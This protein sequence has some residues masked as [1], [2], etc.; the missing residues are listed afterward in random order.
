MEVSLDAPMVDDQVCY[1]Q[2]GG[3]VVLNNGPRNVRMARKDERLPLDVHRA[4]QPLLEEARMD[5]VAEGGL[6]VALGRVG[7]ETLYPLRRAVLKEHAHV[8]DFR[9]VMLGIPCPFA[10][11]R[12]LLRQK[13]KTIKGKQM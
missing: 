9:P 13:L 1:V 10:R 2:F 6:Y 3:T 12:S 5:G 11:S 4:A 8:A 7:E